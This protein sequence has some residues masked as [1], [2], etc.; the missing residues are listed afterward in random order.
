[1]IVERQGLSRLILMF[2][3]ANLVFRI[4][5]HTEEGGTSSQQII[6][7]DIMGIDRNLV[8]PRSVSTGY[9]IKQFGVPIFGILLFMFSHCMRYKFDSSIESFSYSNEEPH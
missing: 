7:K 4:P 9:M 6:L 8:G 2:F 3:I 5:Y 1:M